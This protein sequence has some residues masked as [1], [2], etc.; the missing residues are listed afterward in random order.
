M[1]TNHQSP[2]TKHKETPNPKHQ[3]NTKIQTPNTNKL[4]A[5]KRRADF[6]DAVADG[7]EVFP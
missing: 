2:D 4:P 5:F 6:N 3:R 7:G 1:P